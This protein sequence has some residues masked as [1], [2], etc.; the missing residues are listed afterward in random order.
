ML[1]SDGLS[2]KW[3]IKYYSDL[4]NLQT[5]WPTWLS[6]R[7]NCIVHY[8]DLHN[9]NVLHNKHSSGKKK[10]MQFKITWDWGQ[11]FSL[12]VNC[13]CKLWSETCLE[14]VA[15]EAILQVCI[16]ALYCKVTAPRLPS[17]SPTGLPCTR[18]SYP[19]T[20]KRRLPYNL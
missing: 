20:E 7:D 19:A 17:T 15:D 11:I 12:L 14:K 13:A 10:N 5:T 18:F 16:S 4:G 9:L 1:F 6:F 8:F 2:D 3:M